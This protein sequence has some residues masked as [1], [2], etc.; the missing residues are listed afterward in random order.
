LH[1]SQHSTLGT[2]FIALFFPVNPVI[3]PDLFGS[4]QTI[5]QKFFV[6]LL[7]PDKQG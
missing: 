7:F 1:F 3:S 5:E 4:G 2:F 6:A